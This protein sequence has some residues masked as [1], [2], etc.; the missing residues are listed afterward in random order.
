MAG[1]G[2]AKSLGLKVGEPLPKG[3]CDVA[4]EVRGASFD[5]GTLSVSLDTLGQGEVEGRM[6][7]RDCREVPASRRL[8]VSGLA[9]PDDAASALER[10]LTTP[11]AHLAARDVSFDIPA[12]KGPPKLAA[13]SSEGEGTSE[14]R[15]LGRQVTEWPKPLLAVHPVVSGRVRHEGEMEFAGTVGADG[16]LYKPTLLTSLAQAQEEQVLKVFSL[17]RYEPAKKGQE[18]V[19]ARIRARAT[20][21]IR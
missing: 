20:L 8:T 2:E 3:D 10:L 4:V 19:A 9:S 7:G 16:R 12:E 18:R 17:W 11:E 6:R 13:V 1:A 14:E 5:K 21:R 15:S